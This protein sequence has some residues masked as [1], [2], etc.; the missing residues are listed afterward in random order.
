MQTTKILCNN[1]KSYTFTL[2]PQIIL[3]NNENKQGIIVSD[4]SYQLIF[5]HA[6]C[7]HDV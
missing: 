3:N 2:S 6:Q 7:H 5:I 4:I 1:I